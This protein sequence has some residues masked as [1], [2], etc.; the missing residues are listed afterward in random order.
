MQKCLSKYWHDYTLDSSLHEHHFGDH[1]ANDTICFFPPI[2]ALMHQRNFLILPCSES[3]KFGFKTVDIALFDKRKK[4]NTTMRTHFMASKAQIKARK[5][6]AKRAKRGD[7]RKAIAKTKKSKTKLPQQV[8]SPFLE[9]NI[10][11]DYYKEYKK[12]GGKKNRRQFDK[13][14]DI[15]THH[16]FDIFIHGDPS[17]YA[18]R[19]EALNA[20]KEKAKIDN[21]ELNLI[22]ESIDNV[23]AYT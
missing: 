19:G 18:T 5:L 17:K 9:G 1:I 10:A 6:F 3:T 13:N 4:K 11:D 16:T 8:G 14:V 12:L 7:F 23:T 2:N 22:F 15:F 21:K 20:V